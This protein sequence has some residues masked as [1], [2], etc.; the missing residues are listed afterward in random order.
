MRL[1]WCVWHQNQSKWS[2]QS[3]KVLAIITNIVMKMR[4]GVI[5]FSWVS[6]YDGN[7]DDCDEGDDIKIQKLSWFCPQEAD[8]HHSEAPPLNVCTVIFS[9]NEK[10]KLYFEYHF[11]TPLLFRNPYMFILLFFSWQEILKD[12]T[13]ADAC[14]PQHLGLLLIYHLQVKTVKSFF[15]TVPLIQSPLTCQYFISGYCRCHTSNE[16]IGNM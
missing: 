12:S 7:V 5:F 4:L 9:W 11:T 3:W 15:Y 14:T 6:R 16:A 1:S 8:I 2:F 10:K 13:V